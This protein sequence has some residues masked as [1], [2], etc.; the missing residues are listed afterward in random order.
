MK[1][2]CLVLL[3]AAG[4]CGCKTTTLTN[5]PTIPADVPQAAHPVWIMYHAFEQ[6]DYDM[7]LYALSE[8]TQEYMRQRMGLAEAFESGKTS[9][10]V[11]LKALRF[12][13]SDRDRKRFPNARLKENFSFVQIRHPQGSSGT[14]THKVD[15]EWKVAYPSTIPIED[16]IGT[17][18]L[19]QVPRIRS[20][21]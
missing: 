8:E 11:P 15:G 5:K 19:P 1:Q 18:D 12:S 13:V 3:L 4:L 17:V 21:E 6:D 2:S 9:M 16:M 14:I 10:S 20:G 7:F